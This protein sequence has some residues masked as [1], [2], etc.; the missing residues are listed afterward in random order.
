[1]KRGRIGLRAVLRERILSAANQR[2]A[3]PRVASAGRQ[4]FGTPR[5]VSTRQRHIPRR[6]RAC[7]LFVDAIPMASNFQLIAW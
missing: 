7:D 1:M 5:L 6:N 4:L 3:V 2:A